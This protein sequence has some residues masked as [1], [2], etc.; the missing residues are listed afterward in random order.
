[1]F[2]VITKKEKN[3]SYWKF[4]NKSCSLILL[5]F[6][7]FNYNK[8]IEISFKKQLLL[9]IFYTTMSLLEL[10]DTNEGNFVKKLLFILQQKKKLY[11]YL[12]N[13]A[14]FLFIFIANYLT[15]VLYKNI[16]YSL[17]VNI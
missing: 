2:N 6:F 4:I 15:V 16:F 14:I 12:C 17:Y 10:L 5:I 7:H 9:T 13:I 3:F 1:M 11:F 8:L